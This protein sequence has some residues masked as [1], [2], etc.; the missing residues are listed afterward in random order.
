MWVVGALGAMCGVCLGSIFWILPVDQL[1]AQFR[2]SLNQDQLNQFGNL[3][4]GQLVRGI[5]TA[6]GALSLLISVLILVL[7]GFVRKGNRGATIAALVIYILLA[8]VSALGVLVCVVEALTIMPAALLVGVLW[9][10][11]GGVA[12]LTLFWLVQSL[13]TSTL[14]K[15]QLPMDY[16]RL[17]QQAGLQTPGYGYGTPPGWP[18]QN[19]GPL[20]PPPRKD[21]LPPPPT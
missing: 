6:M 20:P 21:D 10:A 19:L 8:I 5:Y 17:Q 9:L 3:D 11:I 16:I 14:S 15:Q 13:R 1:V 12:G 7:A 2:T 18:Q 4:L